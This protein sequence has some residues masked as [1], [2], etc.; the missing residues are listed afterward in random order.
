MKV[1]VACEFSG[2]VRDAFIARGHDAI[3]CDLRP[4][5]TP[6]PHIQGDVLPLLQEA[7]D[8]IVAFPPCQDLSRASGGSWA[9]KRASGAQQRS[10]E[11]F[12]AIANAPVERIAIENPPGI[13][14]KAWR[15]PDQM[16]NPCQF[17]DTWMKDTCLWLKGL[18]RLMPTFIVFPTSGYWVQATRS[19]KNRARTFP[20]VARAMAYQWGGVNG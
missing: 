6:G 20:G 18:P 14:T 5:E 12:M 16:I 9:K 13:M 17:G 2:V 15:K 4:S 10:Q 11:F 1:L 7:W 19:P 8:L 3:S